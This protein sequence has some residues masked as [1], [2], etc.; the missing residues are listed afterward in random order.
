MI[1]ELEMD[2]DAH[3]PTWPV[4][5]M[6]FNIALKSFNWEMS[7]EMFQGWRTNWSMIVLKFVE[8]MF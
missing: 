7:L 2:H 6:S 5:E 1:R 4:E 3:S 8:D